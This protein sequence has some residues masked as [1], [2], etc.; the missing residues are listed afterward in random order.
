M[1]APQFRTPL[2]YKIVRHPLYLGLII[3][4]WVAPTMTFGRLF[5]AAVLTAYIVVGL[6]LEE[7]DL[8]AEF[9]AT[10]QQYRRAVPMLLPRIFSRRRAED[11]QTEPRGAANTPFQARSTA[12]S[13]GREAK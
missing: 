5:F 12:L 4:F 10:Y 9:G 11:R 1:P 7:R 3:A 13:T 8:V 2:F 6:L